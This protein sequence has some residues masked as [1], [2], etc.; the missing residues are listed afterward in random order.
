MLFIKKF[1]FVG[2]Y[3]SK[4]T[5]I[6]QGEQSLDGFYRAWHQVEYYRYNCTKMSEWKILSK[7]WFISYS[8]ICC[9]LILTH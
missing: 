7:Y 6:R 2:V 1:L 9:L 4:T 3:I 5:Y 8:D